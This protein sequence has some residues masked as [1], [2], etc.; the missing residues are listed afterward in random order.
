MKKIID[1]HHYLG[2]FFFLLFL[3]WFLS[4]FVMMYKSFP[5]LSEENRVNGNTEQLVEGEKL[6]HPSV[7]FEADSIQSINSFRI[8]Y[9]L[10]RP[11]YHLTTTNGKFISKYADDGKPVNI[12]E[13]IAIDIV[14]STT[15]NPYKVEVEKME[16]LDQWV[17]RIKYLKHLPIFNVMLN[18]EANTRIYISSLTGE[19]ISLTNSSDRFWTWVGAI[20]HWIYFKDIRLQPTLW[21]Q[22]VTWL[23]G[24]GFL[25]ALTGIIIGLYRSKKK[26]KTKFK[27]FKSKWY[28]YH[29]YFGLIFGLF[30]CTWV[31]SGFLSMTP[32]NWTPSIS[33]SEANQTKWQG[34]AFTLN[35]FDKESWNNFDQQ[36]KGESFK[37]VQ[38]SLF[39][40]TLFARVFSKEKKELI[41]LNENAIV[42]LA[43]DYENVIRTFNP[44][45]SIIENVLLEEYD[46]YYYSRHNDKM[47]PIIR[48]STASNIAYYVNPST[49]EMVYK[50][51]TRNRIERWIYH[52]LHSLDFSFLTTKGVLWD[53][54]VIFLLIGGTVISMTATGLGI[55]F[56]TRK[57]RKQ[58]KS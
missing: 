15:S 58:L 1:I 56:I 26:P 27:R 50:C 45:D 2:T 13:K 9:Q 55:K 44:S 54:V 25:M 32:F 23:A 43:T 42:P 18:D 28:N 51:T 14:K 40:N 11:V 37:E 17:P 30:V 53:I 33:L 6:L 8:N 29:Y 41:A 19:V 31:F 16:T 3:I 24:L 34:T 12:D 38:F 5:F 21:T 22:L 10:N 7:V 57:I 49:T 35:S 52:G 39:N 4:G 48:I 46:H 47:L 36:L 20:P